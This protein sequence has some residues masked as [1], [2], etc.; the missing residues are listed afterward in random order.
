MDVIDVGKCQNHF[1]DHQ[2]KWHAPHIN[3]MKYYTLQ[4]LQTHSKIKH[5]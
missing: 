1:R 2:E 5:H 3:R 4:D